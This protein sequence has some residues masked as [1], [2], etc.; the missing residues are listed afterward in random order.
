MNMSMPKWQWIALLACVLAG[1]GGGGGYGGGGGGGNGG[2]GQTYTI[3]GTASGLNGSVLLQNNGRDDLLVNHAGAG[4]ATFTFATAVAN[5]GAYAVTVKEHPLNQT[6]AVTS[7]TGTAT[8]NITNVA[9]ACSDLP[10]VTLQAD[11]GVRSVTLS[12]NTPATPAVSSFDVFVEP[13]CSPGIACPD[14]QLLLDVDSPVTVPDLVNA[15]AYLFT[16]ETIFANGAR[17]RSNAAPARPNALVFNG[18]VSAIASDADGNR[19]LGGEFT[20]VGIVSGIAVPLDGATG[21]LATADF[22]IVVGAKVYSV[23]ADGTGGWYLGGEFS[24][25]GGVPR[26]N[27][28]HVLASGAVDPTFDPSPNGDVRTLVVADGVLYAGG[29][30][31]EIGPTGNRLTRNR[32]AAIAA[33]GEVT[34]WRPSADNVVFALAAAGSTI[35]VGGEFTTIDGKARQNLAAIDAAGTLSEEWKPS[36]EGVSGVVEALEVADGTVYVAADFTPAAGLRDHFIRAIDVADGAPV[37][38]TRSADEQVRTL[39]VLGD[40]LYVGGSFTAIDDTP[41]IRLAALSTAG[42]LLDT[43]KP[44]ADDIVKSMAISGSTIYIAGYFTQLNGESHKNAAAITTDG[45]VLDWGPGFN[46]NARTVAVSGNTVYVGG[47]FTATGSATRN[48]LAAVDASGQLLGWN[49]DADGS[50]NALVVA[51]RTVYIGGQFEAIGAEQRLFLAAVGTDGTLLP[52]NPND[53]RVG[54]DNPVHALAIS[55]NTL[56]AGGEFQFIHG[57]RHD[58]LVAIDATSGALLNWD[59]RA[60]GTVQAMQVSGNTVYVGGTFDAIHTNGGTQVNPRNRLAAIAT[61]DAGGTLLDTWK[62]E[63]NDSVD[64]LVVAN[65]AVYVGGFFTQAGSQG[66][67]AERHQLAA[68]GALGASQPGELLPWNPDVSD[69]VNTPKVTSLAASGTT[70][71]VGG[72]FSDIASLGA[73][74]PRNNLAAIGTDGAVLPWNPDANGEVS[75]LAIDGSFVAVGGGFDTLGDLPRGS[76]GVVNAEGAGEVI[77]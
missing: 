25:V 75:E 12:W 58:G 36:N 24:Q 60:S 63:I 22:P 23:V 18:S 41:R 3:G 42:V 8:A 1:C 68:F 46:S 28:A 53:I 16:V 70:L 30:F 39:A 64:A 20:E 72:T 29:E 67:S 43:W 5:G 47:T 71:Y 73:Q 13:K 51:D 76:F 10:R 44:E 33:N 74:F 65:G 11:A 61:V 54:T 77:R 48:H 56:Y 19:Y 38:W 49:P 31:T 17:G 59:V 55:G 21:R 62:P 57:E 50:V 40:T 14:P 2:G 66:M 34:N 37:K 26:K 45:E 9:I 35:Y 7:S 4:T 32:L 27:L 69:D 6:C 52:W 15:Q